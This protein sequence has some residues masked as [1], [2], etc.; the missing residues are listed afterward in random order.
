MNEEISK[1]LD[2]LSFLSRET[3]GASFTIQ[4]NKDN[5]LWKVVFT[6]A[7]MFSK[8][9][10]KH[11]DFTQALKDAIEWIKKE[12]KPIAV[13]EERYTLYSSRSI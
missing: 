11:T 8:E 4:H 6:N 2:E 13:P 9:K 3:N 12:R 10:L 1:L 7:A 5:G